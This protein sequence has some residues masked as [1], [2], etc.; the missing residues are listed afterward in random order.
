MQFDYPSLIAVPANAKIAN[1]DWKNTGLGYSN[2][3]GARG[4]LSEATPR[5]KLSISKTSVVCVQLLRFM[6]AGTIPSDATQMF[7]NAATA[8]S[9]ARKGLV[10]TQQLLRASSLMTYP[11][12]KLRDMAFSSIEADGLTRETGQLEEWRSMF[13]ALKGLGSRFSR[14]SALF[15]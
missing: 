2:Q 3:F 6:S 9:T 11:A 14:R 12:A 4:V 15:A 7:E 10:T 5:L 13:N 8:L 1:A